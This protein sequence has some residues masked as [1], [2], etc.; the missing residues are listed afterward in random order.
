MKLA[1]APKCLSDEILDGES[2]YEPEECERAKQLANDMQD[3][4]IALHI[5]RAK[6]Q[7]RAA[8][9]LVFDSLVPCCPWFVALALDLNTE[10]D[11]DSMCS[12]EFLRSKQIDLFGK[13]SYV[14][15]PV[16]QGTIKYYEPCSDVL[17]D[18]PDEDLLK[19]D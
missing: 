6:D 5:E 7:A 11:S 4:K 13:T 3:F 16:E 10:H 1:V 18:L 19:Y 2:D 15:R 9:D 8:A 12:V 17:E 14:G